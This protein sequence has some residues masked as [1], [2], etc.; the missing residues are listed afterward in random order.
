MIGRYYFCYNR[1]IGSRAVAVT[2]NGRTDLNLEPWNG[3][4]RGALE[5]FF[6]LLLATLRWAVLFF[7]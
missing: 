1:A 4:Q 2:A 7:P 6:F 3:P 5:L